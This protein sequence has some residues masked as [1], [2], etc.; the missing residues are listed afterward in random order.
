MEQAII[1][2]LL[3]K[4]GVTAEDLGRVQA[5]PYP[6]SARLLGELKERV[7][8]NWRKLAGELH[9]DVTGND[10]EKTEEFV[11]LNRVRED[12]EKL[13]VAPRVVFVPFRRPSYAARPFTN[14]ATTTTVSPWYA[15]R[16]RP[17]LE[18][19]VG[20]PLPRALAGDGGLGPFLVFLDGAALVDGPAY[21]GLMSLQGRCP[22]G[23]ALRSVGDGV[24]AF[25]EGLE[26]L[27]DFLSSVV[28]P[29]EDGGDLGAVCEEG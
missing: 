2:R 9:P 4:L 26:E 16:M 3:G 23:P 20:E 24:A 12:F 21:G 7:K 22:G 27:G 10:P 25:D 8:K 17:T 28:D 18:V 1:F 29:Q 14:S 5:L 13:V 6:E 19:V 15:A 11:R